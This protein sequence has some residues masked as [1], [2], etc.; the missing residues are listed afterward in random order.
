MPV[1][2]MVFTAHKDTRGSIELSRRR[3]LS[4]RYL[5]QKIGTRVCR[6]APFSDY[7]V[8]TEIEFVIGKHLQ[9]VHKSKD[10]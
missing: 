5:Y 4:A 10:E 9:I 8:E 6:F 7:M 3:E 1:N 2:D